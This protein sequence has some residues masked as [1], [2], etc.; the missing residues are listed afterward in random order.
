MVC[1]NCNTKV[2]VL[3]EI[4]EGAVE[5]ARGF[6]ETSGIISNEGIYL[7]GSTAWVPSFNDEF[8]TFDLTT[9]MDSAWGVVSQGTRTKNMVSG[10]RRTIQYSVT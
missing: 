2:K 4:K 10:N 6:S 3:G 9:V 5:Y 1:F 7:A 8:F